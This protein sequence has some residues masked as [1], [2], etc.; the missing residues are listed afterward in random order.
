MLMLAEVLCLLPAL[1]SLV[2]VLVCAWFGGGESLPV[3]NEQLCQFRAGNK[4]QRSY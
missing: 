3:P 4:H 1:A 2:L